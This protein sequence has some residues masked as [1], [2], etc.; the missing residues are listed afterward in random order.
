M[1]VGEF[2]EY[3]WPVSIQFKD[4]VPRAESSVR[5]TSGTYTLL[6]CFASLPI[7][8]YFFFSLPAGASEVD[9][10]KLG[11]WYMYFFDKQFGESNLHFQ[12]DIQHRNWDLGGDLEQ[13]LLRGGLAYNSESLPG[14]FTFG[15][16]NITSGEFGSSDQRRR[17]KR[18][19]Q[20]ALFSNTMA[21]NFSVRHRLRLEQR[22]VEN[23]D[24]R[25]RFRYAFFA[26]I[27]LNSLNIERGSWYLSF[28]NEIFLN[29]ERGIGSGRRVH[30]YDRNRS[31]A[32]LGYQ[33]TASI[34]IQV[35]YMYQ[36]S[37]SSSKGQLQLS[38]HHQF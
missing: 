34:Q 8:I 5:P 17:E 18:I 16:A 1:Q 24:F 10:D 30:L 12:G 25:T 38:M 28:Y 11:A 4:E 23:Q 29:G 9:R 20:E 37:E 26:N 2:V 21:T 22:W 31:Y 6:N 27:P 14:R 7:I 13:L 32:A 35:G 15:F 3:L 19:Y 36:H 33:H